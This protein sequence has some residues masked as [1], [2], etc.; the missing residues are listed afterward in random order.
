MA[1]VTHKVGAEECQQPFFG[2]AFHEDFPFIMTPQILRPSE[3]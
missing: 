1:F 2:E 3:E